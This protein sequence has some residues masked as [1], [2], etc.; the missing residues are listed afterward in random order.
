MKIFDIKLTLTKKN[1]HIIILDFPCWY[2]I[3]LLSIALFTF[4]MLIITRK[5]NNLNIFNRYN[6]IP[7]IVSFLSIIFSLYNECWIFDKRKKNIN[8][9]FGLLFFYK[10]K[11]IMMD[12]LLEIELSVIDKR[13]LI[14]QSQ[15][16]NHKI[17][18]NKIIRLELITKDEK[19]FIIEYYNISKID[20][21][22]KMSQQIASLCGV[23]LNNRVVI[24]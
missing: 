2:R 16:N 4:I 15:K 7:L 21:I 12:D 19:K 3:L 20:K 24:D 5:N 1:N 8:H 9:R 17:L 6:L 23:N 18:S 11:L 13:R 22:R 10:T 14:N